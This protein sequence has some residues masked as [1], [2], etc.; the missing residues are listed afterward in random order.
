V[1]W[2]IIVLATERHSRALYWIHFLVK[3]PINDWAG[4]TRRLAGLFDKQ[5]FIL[6]TG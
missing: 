1:G 4:G 6:E 2:G 3:A 5:L